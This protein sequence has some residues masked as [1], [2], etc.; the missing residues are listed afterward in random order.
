MKKIKCPVT[1][2]EAVTGIV[3]TIEGLQGQADWSV[4]INENGLVDYT[5]DALQDHHNVVTIPVVFW[6]SDDNSDLD[7]ESSD[8][9]S[10]QEKL[11]WYVEEFMEK[12]PP[13]FENIEFAEI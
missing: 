3:N 12:T 11:D 9:M 5:C 8:E 2:R 4:G 1:H 13:G 10:S 6:H 7:L